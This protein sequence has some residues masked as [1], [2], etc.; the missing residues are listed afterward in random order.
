MVL[1]H[2]GGLEGWLR[3]NCSEVEW[4]VALNCLNLFNGKEVSIV[5]T[6]GAKEVTR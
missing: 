5:A 2:E 3:E 1:N 6:T 4:K